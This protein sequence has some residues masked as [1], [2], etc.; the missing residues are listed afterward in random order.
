MKYK[1][2]LFSSLLM[3][4]ILILFESFQQYYYILQF[5][6]VPS[7]QFSILELTIGHAYRWAVWMLTSLLYFGIVI[8]TGQ[9][10]RIFNLTKVWPAVKHLAILI[11][12]NVI[13][14]SILHLVFANR[15]LNLENIWDN[16]VFFFFQKAPIY[17]LSYGAMLGLFQMVN[18]NQNLAIEILNLQN[19][20][21]TES[22]QALS[23]KI[24]NKNK[25]IPLVDIVWIEAYDYCVKI[26][27]T[28]Q[29]TYAMRNSLKAL[30]KRLQD[31]QFLRVHRRA[32]VN[33]EKVSE[34]TYNST[35]FLTLVDQTKIDIAQSRIADIKS[36]LQ[37]AN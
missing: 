10:D 34:V 15:S 12:I 29:H 24:G 31:L 11:A 18:T 35:S 27:T 14:I 17:T 4:G 6:L 7:G 30:E 9:S 22:P 16:C 13:L 3:V 37:S 21:R 32:I 19:Q 8:Y 26:H 1:F 2:F 25:I 36:Y 28:N 23:I 5:D 33:M 20:V